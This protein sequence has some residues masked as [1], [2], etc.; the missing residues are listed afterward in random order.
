MGNLCGKES[1]PEPFSQPGR[2]LS[3]APAPSNT[4]TSAVP[5]KVGGP[6]QKL[7]G[8]N[9]SSAQTDS[10][11]DDARRKAAEAAVG[12]QEASTKKTKRVSRLKGPTDEEGRVLDRAREITAYN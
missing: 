1:T 11:N 12:R 4:N 5:R 3:S 8:S 2:T 10:Q 7:G 6:P 9:P